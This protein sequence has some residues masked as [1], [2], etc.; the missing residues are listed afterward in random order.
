MEGRNEAAAVSR[1]RVR[2][3]DRVPSKSC[4]DDSVREASYDLGWVDKKRLKT[5]NRW[6]DKGGFNIWHKDEDGFFEFKSKAISDIDMARQ[7]D[8]RIREP[9]FGNLGK[10]R[11][12]SGSSSPHSSPAKK[13]RSEEVASNLHEFDSDMEMELANEDGEFVGGGV[14]AIPSLESLKFQDM[15]SLKRWEGLQAT[16]MPCL[17]ELNITDCPNLTVLPSLHLLCSLVKLEI[18]YCPVV[19]ALP[20][21]GFPLSMETLIIVQS[22][23]LKQR[24][25]PGQGDWEKIKAIRKVLVDFVQIHT[26]TG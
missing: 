20:E 10:K 24:C 17:R 7:W 5:L 1:K 19:Q 8:V 12:N 26:L 3:I 16:Q 23:F 9:L 11:Q 4:D 18:S 22:D 14:A 21:E 6:A 13:Q 15:M 2:T 25:L